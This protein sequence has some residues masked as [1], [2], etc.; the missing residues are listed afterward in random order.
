MQEEAYVGGGVVGP[1][2]A[3]GR[4]CLILSSLQK[5]GPRDQACQV[6]CGSRNFFHGMIILEFKC[7]AGLFLF[8]PNGVCVGVC[9]GVLDFLVG[10]YVGRLGLPP[11]QEYYRVLSQTIWED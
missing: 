1:L 7:G 5:S 10:A 9:M 2:I 6:W 11:F 8:Q 3:H 4:A